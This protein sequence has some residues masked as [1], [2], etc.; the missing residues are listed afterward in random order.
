MQWAWDP[1]KNRENKQKHHL[2]FEIAIF[3]FNDP[4]RLTQEDPYL[5]EPRYRTLGMVGPV[6]LLV[7]HTLPEINLTGLE[8]P[9]RIIS[10]RKATR[11]E[12]EQYEEGIF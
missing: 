9:G 1:D 5:D 6:T 4:L 12:K 10:A 2:S 11:G 8:Q 7:I 3:V